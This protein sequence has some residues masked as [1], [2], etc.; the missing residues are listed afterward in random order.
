MSRFFLNLSAWAAALGL[1]LTSET[2]LA[3]TLRL[4]TP[5]GPLLGLTTDNGEVASFK[6][7]PYALPPVGVRRW[8]PAQPAPAWTN[9]RLAGQTGPAC[10]QS[11]MPETTEIAGGGSQPALYWEPDQVSG[12]DCLYLNVWAPAEALKSGQPP[13]PVMVWIHG[14]AFLGGSGANPVYD[15]E[16]LARKGVVVV[17]L[18]YRLG[19]FGFFAHPELSAESPEGLSGNYGLTDQME[20]LRWVRKNIAAFGGDPG[21]V[22]IF[23]ES[24]GSWAVNLL[25][26]NHQA[27]G[28]FH[29]AIGQS[30][31]Y[32]YSMLD[33]KKPTLGRGS[34][35]AIGKAFGDTVVAG[36][37]LADLRALPA[38]A[39]LAAASVPG[40]INPG[41]FVVVDGRMFSKPVRDI[42]AAG[43]Q[44]AV[45]V[46]V[47]FNADE[48]SGLSDFYVVA[49][50]PPSA[51]A[52]EAQVKTRFGDLARDWLKLYPAS[53]LTGAAFNAYRDS[54]FGWR[55][56]AWAGDTS[57]V[58][59]PAY[60]YFFNHTP[61]GGEQE[62]GLPLYL[63]S[64]AKRRAGAFHAS[65]IAYVFNNAGR[66][67]GG[68]L[69][70]APVPTE[71][72]TRLA[73][74]MS[75]YWVAFATRGD[76]N[77]PGRPV[78]KPYSL[79]ARHYMEFAGQPRP[80]VNLMPGMVELHEAVDARRMKAGIPWD[81]ASAGLFAHTLPLPT[82]SPAAP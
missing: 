15:G 42:Y 17:T 24:A 54:E 76:P 3:A 51:A 70:V 23:G 55:M 48:G 53:D 73:D 61:P 81:G 69:E 21:N 7:I 9:L 60:L 47:G 34:A 62:R 52:Y 46:M 31:A 38:H 75:D 30:G 45:P 49:P 41:H 33:L 65:E 29:K 67:P 40:A 32:F 64:P 25:V 10:I 5:Q 14:G 43:E 27:K 78:W 74:Q 6:G 2:V 56:Q 77:G 28:L 35:E 12:E 63:G 19:V 82:P 57:R 1:L 11:G 50:P 8:T 44:A 66:A 80:G 39:L 79:D 71:T 59:Q 20:A 4:N 36:G 58:G 16:A 26:A 37:A 22:T 68:S 13:R 72:D 18:N